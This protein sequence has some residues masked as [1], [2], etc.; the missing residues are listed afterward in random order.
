MVL[1]NQN[2][3]I[4]QDFLKHV[5]ETYNNSSAEERAEIRKEYEERKEIQYVSVEAKEGSEEAKGT[6]NAT[7]IAYMHLVGA[8]QK[9]ASYWYRS[10]STVLLTNQIKQADADTNVSAIFLYIDSGGGAVSGTFELGEAI[11]KAKKPVIA[12]ISDT[13]CS[14][15]LWVASQCDEAYCTSPTGNIGSIDVLTWHDDYSVM[16]EEGYGI[17]RTYITSDLSRNKVLGNE[18]EPLTEDTQERIRQTLIPTK[19]IFRKTIEKGRGD[20]LKAT[21]ETFS[22][23][24]FDAL[25]AKE[26]GLIDGII[27][28]EDIVAKAGRAGRRFLREQK[29]QDKEKSKNAN[30]HSNTN[31][32][33]SMSIF[34]KFLNTKPQAT[35][36]VVLKKEEANTLYT[37]LEEAT[38]ANNEN[39]AK[40]A[41]LSEQLSSATAANE[42][43]ASKISD[44]EA[45][46]AELTDQVSSAKA[47]NASELEAKVTELE[48]EKAEAAEKVTEL[49]AA[50]TELEAKVTA[51]EEKITDLTSR[52]EAEEAKVVK[53]NESYNELAKQLGKELI[54]VAASNAKEDE[55]EEEAQKA[56][57]TATSSRK[58]VNLFAMGKTLKI[59]AVRK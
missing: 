20:R 39:A 44:L 21:S 15:A 46:V 10:T 2:L 50:N 14:A 34:D 31:N 27:S 9:Q 45:K 3:A 17:K 55:K 22:G 26:M 43:Q 5:V 18:V 28:I 24:T 53:A 8:M 4:D 37:M 36:D 16:L 47:E 52:V 33:K 57:T 35:E 30:N 32:N 11:R 59:G 38:A 40:V 56:E 6:R 54:D 13:C 25:T 41:E 42:D 51:S 23:S 49:E 1:F 12:A 19:K 29:K 48:G 7:T 58:S